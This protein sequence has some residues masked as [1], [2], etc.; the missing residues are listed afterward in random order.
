M[1]G[2]WRLMQLRVGVIPLPVYLISTA[3]LAYLLL[4]EFPTDINV[5]IAVLAIGGSRVRSWGGGY[6]GSAGPG[7]FDRGHIHSP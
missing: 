5:A 4:G 3:V 6:P 1:R 2:W 7:G